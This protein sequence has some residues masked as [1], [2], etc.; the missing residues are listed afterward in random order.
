[1]SILNKLLSESSSFIQSPFAFQPCFIQ[2]FSRKSTSHVWYVYNIQKYINAK[3]FYENNHQ[4]IDFSFGETHPFH[5]RSPL[6]RT[7]MEAR[8]W[9]AGRWVVSDWSE[10]C[11]GKTDKDVGEWIWWEPHMGI[12]HI[13][14]V[15]FPRDLLSLCPNVPWATTDDST[16]RAAGCRLQTGFRDF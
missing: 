9:A 7:D 13:R 12:W 3:G 5:W 10:T 11:V 2:I 8:G 15:S 6:K 1:M 4:K 14:S 16:R